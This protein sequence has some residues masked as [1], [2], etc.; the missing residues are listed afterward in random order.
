VHWKEVASVALLV[1]DQ[2]VPELLN[3]TALILIETFTN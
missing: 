2:M 3:M 1:L